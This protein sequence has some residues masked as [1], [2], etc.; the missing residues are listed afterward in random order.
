MNIARISQYLFGMV[1]IYLGT[2]LAVKSTIG[3]G[4]WSAL[5]V[6]LSKSLPFSVGFWFAVSQVIIVFINAFLLKGR[7]EWL[8]FIPIV[9]ES[10]IFDFWLEFVFKDIHFDDAMLLTRVGIF[11]LA[12]VI[13]SFGI[14]LY[15][16]TGL[17]R[18][19]VDQLFISISQRFRWKIGASQTIVAITVSSI[20]FMLGGPVGVGTVISIFLFGPCIQF[21]LQRVTKIKWFNKSSISVQT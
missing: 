1:I 21:W 15:V 7:P 17:P 13:A 18:S 11:T 20:A 2:T 14:A 6:G 4:F 9:L 3:A 5:F 8:A 10:I 19:P 12:L 16:L